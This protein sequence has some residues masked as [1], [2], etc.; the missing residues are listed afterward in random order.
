MGP[1]AAIIDVFSVLKA[2]I[3]AVANRQKE[4]QGITDVAGCWWKGAAELRECTIMIAIDRISGR[5]I[6]SLKRSK[7]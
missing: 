3:L 1:R 4:L 6:V 5:V 7:C 2:K